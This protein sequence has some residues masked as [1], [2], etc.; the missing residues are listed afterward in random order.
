MT[1][2]SAGKPLSPWPNRALAVLLALTILGLH[3]Y[4]LCHAGGL[5]RDEVNSVNLAGMPSL[6]AMTQDSFPVLFPL[7]LKFWSALGLG[8]T[9]GHL[10]WLGALIGICLTVALWLAAWSARRSVPFLSLTLVALNGSMIFWGDS[11]R[12][13][14]LG[15]ALIVFSMAAMC[16][17][18]EKPSWKRTA[19]LA[20]LA[21]LSVQALYQNAVLFGGVAAGGWLVCWLRKDRGTALKILVAGLIAFVSVLP[22]WGC[23]TRWSQSA[24]VIRP[25]FS[26]MAVTGN[27]KTVVAFPLPQ[28][29]WVWIALGGMVVVLGL[30]SLLQPRSVVASSGGQ[31]TQTELRVFAGGV[32][33][34]AVVGYFLFLHFAA[35]I[36]EPWYFLPLVAVIGV[37]FDLGI[38]LLQLP[39]LWK[40]ASFGALAATAVIAAIFGLRDLNCRFTNIDLAAAYLQDKA[41]PQDYVVVTP[42]YLGISF[43]RYYH[44]PANWDTLPPV[45]DHATHRFDLVPASDLEKTRAMQPVLDRIASTLQAGHQVWVVG[46]MSVPAP[47]HVAASPEARFIAEHS[48][49]FEPADLKIPG[50]ISDFECVSLLQAHGWKN[51][52]P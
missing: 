28:F 24:M 44:A 23:V 20:G 17:L 13:F 38:N 14:G 51:S 41:A 29:V 8:G 10:R 22:Y 4:F 9:D 36:T 12:A 3:T 16:L 26:L 25:G 47:G 52:L 15:S 45:A 11:L 35:L 46:W 31:L 49:Q 1:M 42:W 48:V 32:L 33:L 6:A 18:L 37:C 7:L 30:I 27:L 2:P 50:Q 34:M 19:L 39:R 40:T 43:N 5:W 21:V